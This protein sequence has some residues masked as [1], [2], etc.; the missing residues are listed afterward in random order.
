MLNSFVAKRFMSQGVTD[1]KYSGK[2]LK[3][4]LEIR[5]F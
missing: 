3:I 5:I 2:P 1:S 4:G